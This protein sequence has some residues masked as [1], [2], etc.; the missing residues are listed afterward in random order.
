MSRLV[1]LRVAHPR[2][3]YRSVSGF[4]INVHERALDSGK[5]LQLIL[6][7]LRKVVGLPEWCVPRHH[8][9]DFEE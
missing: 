6:H 1:A 5:C 3:T 4:V 9:V 8:D 7:L 2:I